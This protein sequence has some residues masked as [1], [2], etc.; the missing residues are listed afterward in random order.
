MCMDIGVN[1]ISCIGNLKIGGEA[2]VDGYNKW[3]KPLSTFN[4]YVNLFNLP[5]STSMSMRMFA[6]VYPGIRSERM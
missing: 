2:G 6:D 1:N 3:E 5:F 4:M